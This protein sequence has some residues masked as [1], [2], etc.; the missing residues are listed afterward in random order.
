MFE[1]DA[2]IAVV[3]ETWFQDSAVA[4]TAVDLAGEHG[5][6]LFTLNRQVV[7]ANG[8]QYGGVAISTRNCRSTFKKVD[9]ANPDSF[10]VLCIAG[11]VRGISEKIVVVAVYLPPN[12][13]KTKKL[14]LV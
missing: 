6:D 4:D 3:T 11:K 2:D 13:T 1:I 7:A 9:I 14:M 5:L 12:Y 10:E 8:R